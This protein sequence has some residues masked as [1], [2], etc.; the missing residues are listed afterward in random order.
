M[1]TPLGKKP[2]LVLFYLFGDISLNPM[3][4]KERPRHVCRIKIL[5]IFRLRPKRNKRHGHIRSSAKWTFY[6]DTKQPKHLHFGHF[7][8]IE[9]LILHC[10]PP[11]PPPPTPNP[12]LPYPHCFCLIVKHN[13]SLDHYACEWNSKMQAPSYASSKLRLTDW[14]TYRQGWSV[15]LLA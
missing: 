13:R 3:W 2:R 14:R 8:S 5:R 12:P 15:E 9:S 1:R 6:I 10:T 11:P 4:N 7:N